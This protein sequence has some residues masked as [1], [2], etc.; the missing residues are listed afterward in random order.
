MMNSGNSSSFMIDEH[1]DMVSNAKA[2]HCGCEAILFWMN[3]YHHITS[4]Q[5]LLKDWGFHS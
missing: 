5:M 2:L 4:F 1:K 3:I